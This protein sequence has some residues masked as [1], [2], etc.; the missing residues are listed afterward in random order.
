LRKEVKC[1]KPSFFL[2]FS[3]LPLPAKGEVGSGHP[4]QFPRCAVAISA[5]V[6]QAKAAD[7]GARSFSFYG[8]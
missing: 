7:Y 1:A 4:L 5:A 2:F 6:P 8:F 3:G